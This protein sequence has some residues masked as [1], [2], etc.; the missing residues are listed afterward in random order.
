[1][2][3]AIPTDTPADVVLL[4]SLVKLPLMFVSGILVPITQLPSWILPIALL[5]PI[6]YPADFVRMQYLGSSFLPPYLSLIFTV[7]FAL[8]FMILALELHEKS[9][10]KRL[11]KR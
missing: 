5:S 7:L 2:F 11:E 4:S 3:S 10:F 9:I 1:M 8:V 6:T